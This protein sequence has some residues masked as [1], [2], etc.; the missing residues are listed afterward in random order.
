MTFQSRFQLRMLCFWFKQLRVVTLWYAQTKHC[1]I[2]ASLYSWFS[3]WLVVCSVTPEFTEKYHEI[4]RPPPTKNHTDL[5]WLDLW[6][7]C[8]NLDYFW[9][10]KLAGKVIIS[11]VHR[12]GQ[13]YPLFSILCL[14]SFKTSV[15]SRK[16]RISLKFIDLFIFLKTYDTLYF[17]FYQGFYFFSWFIQDL[18]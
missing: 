18:E 1:I 7:F 8:G 5:S 11:C 6:T 15:S 17:I 16:V 14:S 3:V 10:E 9:A 12:T 13:S 2:R 4:G